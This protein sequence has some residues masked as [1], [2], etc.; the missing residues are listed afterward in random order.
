[1]IRNRENCFDPV[2][3]ICTTKYTLTWK[4]SDLKKPFQKSQRTKTQDNKTESQ[5]LVMGVYYAIVI[6]YSTT[7]LQELQV[8]H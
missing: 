4:A 5:V 2:M 3:F 7:V 6:Y 8:L 1:M